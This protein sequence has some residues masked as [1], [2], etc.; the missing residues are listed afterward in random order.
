[1]AMEMPCFQSAQSETVPEQRPI[2]S[3]RLLSAAIEGNADVIMQC[4]GL[5]GKQEVK[6]IFE[7]I[8][9]LIVNKL[10]GGQILFHLF[11]FFL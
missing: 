2:M 7:E 11:L 10:N 4:L 5:S 3:A 6:V 8:I 9:F 1:M